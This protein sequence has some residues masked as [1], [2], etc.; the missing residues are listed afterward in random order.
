MKNLSQ[1]F[2]IPT[3]EGSSLSTLNLSENGVDPSFFGMTKIGYGLVL[4]FCLITPLYTLAQTTGLASVQPRMRVIVD[5]DF[6]GDPDGLFQLAHLLMSPSVEVRAI[7]GSHLRVGDGFDR[8]TTQADNAAKKAR[9][10]LAVMNITK[11]IPVFAGSN[12]TVRP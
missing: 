9:E 8:S 12:T 5:N 11:P 4:I 7:I 6:S 1:L 10:V 2:V 3:K